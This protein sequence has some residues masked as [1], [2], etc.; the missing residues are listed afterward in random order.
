M[1]S[2]YSD[3]PVQG[4]CKR[5]CFLCPTN[6]PTMAR[7]SGTSLPIKDAGI[8][9]DSNQRLFSSQFRNAL[10]PALWTGR[11]ASSQEVPDFFLLSSQIVIG[12]QF[13]LRSWMP[14]HCLRKVPSLS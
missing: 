9:D 13:G 7:L 12:Q 11:A 4:Q 1:I 6:C 14:L 10:H 2:H 8:A 3:Q 5:T